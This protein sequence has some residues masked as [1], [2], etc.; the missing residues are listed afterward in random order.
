[1]KKR[2]KKP[3][4]HKSELTRLKS[5]KLPYAK[6]DPTF[7]IRSEERERYRLSVGVFRNSE[8]KRQFFKQLQL[9]S[10]EEALDNFVQE[11]GLKKTIRAAKLNR[12]LQQH[13]FKIIKAS[14]EKAEVHIFYFN[15]KPIPF[16]KLKNKLL[17]TYPIVPNH[18]I[19]YE[20]HK[21]ACMKEA[22]YI[23]KIRGTGS[24]VFIKVLI[25]MIV[26]ILD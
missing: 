18:P 23:R 2:T 5:G 16:L 14:P 19:T 1:M 6:L 11:P 10:R 13:E 17:Q 22:T 24:A 8:S 3:S 20:K 12:Q 21:D 9:K 4:D 25:N 26:Q 15:L 7:K